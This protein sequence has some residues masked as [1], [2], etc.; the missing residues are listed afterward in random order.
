MLSGQAIANLS[1]TLA[2]H[3]WL[4]HV[5]WVDVRGGKHQ[6]GAVGD[7]GHRQLNALRYR[8]RTVIDSGQQMKVQ[9]NVVH[10]PM[11]GVPDHDPVTIV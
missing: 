7:R 4:G 9:L 3:P 6:P 11:I 5:L 1:D 2:D 10:S 8:R